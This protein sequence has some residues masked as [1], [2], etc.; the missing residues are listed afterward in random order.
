MSIARALNATMRAVAYLGTPYEMVVETVPVPTLQNA[1]DAI[2][3]VT[4]AAICGSDLHYYHGTFG[5]GT[6][7]PWYMGH[8]AVGYVDA[9]GEGVYAISEGDYVVIPDITASHDHFGLTDQLGPAYGPGG[10]GGCQ[11]EHDETVP[12]FH[13]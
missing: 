12:N 9:V 6:S 8:E 1:T 13:L 5:H 3:R 4:T 7:P 2:V 11:G 10:L